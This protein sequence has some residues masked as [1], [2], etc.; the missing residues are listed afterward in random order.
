[1]LHILTNHR[2]RADFTWLLSG[3][4]LYSACQWGIVVVLAKL[5]SPQQVGEYALGMAVAS[6]V[7]LFANC[8]LRSFL[9]SDVAGEYTFDE[10]VGF[11]FV[12]LTCSLA[13]IAVLAVLTQPNLRL[14]SVII[15][16]GAAQALECIS[17][18]YYGFMQK[19]EQMDRISRSLLLKGPLSLA[20]LCVAMFIARNVLVAIG[21]LCLGRLLVVLLWDCRLGDIRVKPIRPVWNLR[22]MRRLGRLVLPLGI[23]A[24]L[25]SLAAGVP[26]YFVAGQLGSAELGIFSAAA[27]LVTAGNLVVSAYSQAMFLSAAWAYTAAEAEAFRGFIS[28]AFAMGGALGAMAVLGTA[29]FGQWMLVHIFRPEY[30]GSGR[31]LIVLMTAGAVSFIASGLGYI[32]TA[33][34][35]LRPQIP[36]L[37]ASV[38]AGAGAS[39]LWIPR[40][41]LTGA[42]AAVLCTSIV[43]LAGMA[44]IAW[45]VSRELNVRRKFIPAALAVE[46]VPQE[47]IL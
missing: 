13:V 20:A 14:A 47:A 17:D 6:P 28:L 40:Y 1:M 8:Q 46:K 24:M 27:S 31:V 26:R 25:V 45:R 15:L 19:R 21:A 12:T 41:G 16:V 2:W 5:G 35:S 7:I 39:V 32:I 33:A 44:A 10:Y 22:G 36:V 3:N 43:Q 42:A 29:S 23:I 34:R 9:V 18:T 37:A 4:V 30:G 38:C 11:R